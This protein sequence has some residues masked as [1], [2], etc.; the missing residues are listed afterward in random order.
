MAGKEP[1]GRAKRAKSKGSA[2]GRGE[3]RVSRGEAGEEEDEA[4]GLSSVAPQVEPDQGD[5]GAGYQRK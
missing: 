2:Q 1:E 5:R 4:R 3:A